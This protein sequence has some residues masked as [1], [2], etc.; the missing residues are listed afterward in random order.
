M[1]TKNAIVDLTFQQLKEDF[2]EDML[3]SLIFKLEI[4]LRERTIAKQL[5]ED[6]NLGKL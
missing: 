2:D 1:I 5:S 3:D 6:H 4:E